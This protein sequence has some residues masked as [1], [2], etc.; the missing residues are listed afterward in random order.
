LAQ[1]FSFPNAQI[2]I[3]TGV[4]QLPVLSSS[5]GEVRTGSHLVRLPLCIG[6]NLSPD[7][8]SCALEA[9]AIDGKEINRGWW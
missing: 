8:S 4:G 6:F 3:T 9:V 2:S 5:E 7:A 1:F